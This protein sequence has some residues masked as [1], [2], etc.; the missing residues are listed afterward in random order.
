MAIT[1]PT[2]TP[3]LVYD[4]GMSGYWDNVTTL[5]GTD[6]AGLDPNVVSGSAVQVQFSRAEA[7]GVRENVALFDL[8]FS[9]NAGL[10]AAWSELS[11]TTLSSVETALD[12]LWTTLKANTPPHWL[13]SG[14]VWRHF[15]ADY[16]LGKTGLSKPSPIY[17]VTSRS[18]AGTSAATNYTPDQMAISVTFRTA[19]RKHWGRVYLPPPI[20]NMV[21]Q[22]GRLTTGWCDTCAGAFDTLFATVNGLPAQTHPVIWSSKYRGFFAVDTLA[23]DDVPDVIRRRR[24]Y[25]RTY[26]KTYG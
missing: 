7:A 13:L 17:R 5:T 4:S 8:H 16:P 23:V 6:R 24:P 19:S 12:T 25:S 26:I 18:V 21:T 15:G 1:S 10:G 11:D 9:T 20:A 2:Y 14:Y 3:F 22:Y